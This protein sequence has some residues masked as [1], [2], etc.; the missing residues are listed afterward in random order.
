MPTTTKPK[1]Q[2]SSNERTNSLLVTANPAEHKIIDD[3]VRSIDVEEPTGAVRRPRS[4]EPYLHVYTAKTADVQEVAKTLNVL[5]P[6][7]VVNEDGRARRLHIFATPTQHELIER[8]IKQLDG[9]GINGGVSVAVIPTGRIDSLTAVATLHAVFLADKDAAPSITP[10]PTGYGLIVRGTAD[11]VTQI[12]SLLLQMDPNAL[13]GDPQKGNVRTIPLGGRDTEEFSQMLKQLWGAKNSNPI[14]VVPSNSQPVRDQRVPSAAPSSNQPAPSRETTRPPRAASR[15]QADIPLDKPTSA[16]R[17]TPKAN[18]API[19]QPRAQTTQ[20]TIFTVSL[21]EETP[22]KT[23]EPVKPNKGK[24]K[25]ANA[26]KKANPNKQKKAARKAQAAPKAETTPKSVEPANETPATDENGEPI[27]VFSSGGNLVI[28]SKDEAA[29]DDMERLIELMQEATPSKPRWTIFYLRSADAS[30]TAAMLERLFPTS[31][32]SSGTSSSTG[33]L[34]ELTGGMSSMGRSLMNATGL[35]SAMAGSLTLR[36]IPDMRSNALYVAGPADQIR[37]V[38]AMLRVL[39]ASEL[40][41]QLRDRT[42][43]RIQVQHAEVEDVAA[44]VREIYKDDMTPEGQQPG[45]QPN[46]FAMLMG[47]GGSSRGG[48]S[49]RGG[50]QQAR[51]IKLTLSVD[52]R[53]NTLIISSS[54]SLFRQIESLVQSIDDDARAANRTVRVVDIKGS[55]SAAVQTALSAM[56]SKIKT[57]SSTRSSSSSSSSRGSPSSSSGSSSPSPFGSG[58]FTPGMPFMPPFGGF[59]SSPFGGDR[60]SDSSRSSRYSGSPFGSGGP[61]GGGR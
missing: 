23:A 22:E 60:G 9:E 33:M 46:P 52:A 17:K 58:G 1:V 55:N 24:K 4:R 38:E 53:T 7:C 10:H 20:A 15:P 43:H 50:Q 30:E 28:T 42:P 32:V 44:I 45:Q 27:R 35:S 34:G 26:N 57:S 36:I 61:P 48:S 29:L 13:K 2:V 3:L 14:I 51:S 56:Y 41:E 6:G 18:S 40:P 54:E 12:K 21:L 49:S 31:S 25:T 16:K 8:T 39:D 5:Y 19:T 37:E 11:Q 59:G 47:G